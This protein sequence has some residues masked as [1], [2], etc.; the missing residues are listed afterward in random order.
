MFN[1][2]RKAGESGPL[3]ISCLVNHLDGEKA[4]GSNKIKRT[5]IP[6]ALKKHKEAKKK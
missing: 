1:K 3:G 5:G 2:K 6:R 4:I